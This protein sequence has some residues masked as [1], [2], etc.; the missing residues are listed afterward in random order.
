MYFNR[1]LYQ[2]TKGARGQLLAA[3]A[4]GLLTTGAGVGR[5]AF[6]GVAIAFLIEGRESGPIIMAF[7]AVILSIIVRAICQYGKEYLGHRAALRVQ[8]NMRRI[9]YARALT[10]GPGVLDQKRAGDLLVSLVEGVDQLESYFGEFIPQV[11]VAALT[12]LGLFVFMG[13]L[14]LTTAL[15]YLVC[16][17]FTLGAPWAFHKWN[18]TSSMKRRVSYGDLSAEFLDSVQGLA[19]LK[20]FGQSKAR[21]LVLAEKAREVYVNTMGIL[22]RNVGTT[23]VTWLGI[24][25]GAAIA[26]SFGAL[27][28]EQGSLELATLLVIVM[29]GV[30]VFRPLRELTMLYHKGMLGTSAATAIFDLLDSKV[31]V[32]STESDGN[33]LGALDSELEFRNV[34]FSYPTNDEKVLTNVSFKLSQGQT[35]GIV[36]PS[37]AGKSTLIWLIMRLFDPRSGDVLI[38]GKRLQDIPI[39]LL[40]ENLAVVTQDTYLFHGT[41]ADN[42][43]MANANATLHEIEI[44]ARSANA[45]DFIV[46][47]PNGYDT[48]IGERGIRLSGGQRQRIAIARALLK[49]A[50][51]LLLDE[52]LSNVDTENELI[53]QEAL[54]RLMVGR[55]TLV[56]AHRLSS[57]VGTDRI[58]VFDRGQLVQEG[59]HHKLIDETGVYYDLMSSQISVYSDG[60]ETYQSRAEEVPEVS[61]HPKIDGA[62]IGE[63]S[64]SDII[65]SGENRESIGKVAL[66][67][68]AL[69][70]PWKGMLTATFLLGVCRVSVLI[71]IGVTSALLVREVA[72]QQGVHVTPFVIILAVLAFLTPVFHWAESWLSHD[73][74][75]RLLAE[76]RVAL[77]K[78]LDPLAPAYLVKRRSGDIVALV[79]SDIET[80]EYFFGHTVAPAFVAL[81]VP[82]VVIVTMVIIQWEMAL[83][84][85]PFLLL[86]G[87]APVFSSRSLDKGASD[88]REKLGEINAHM[89]DGVQGMREIVAF[90]A[91]GKRLNE[92]V[93]NQRTFGQYRLHFLKMLTIQKVSIEIFIGI[94][95]ISVLALGA[96]FVDRGELAGTLLPLLSLIALASF[97]PVTELAQVAKSL[98]DTFASARRIFSVHDE[99]IPVKDGPGVNIESQVSGPGI[100][101]QNVVFSYGRGLDNALNDMSFEVNEGDTVAIVGRS[102]AG[103]TTSAHLLLRFW[104]PDS[105]S[106]KFSGHDL[107]GF[108]LDQLRERISMVSQDTYLFNTTIKENLRMAKPNAEEQEIIDAAINANMHDFVMGLPKQ[109][110][111]S[112]GERGMHLS[113]GQRQRLA[114]ARALLK[115][116][117]ILILDEATSHLDVVNENLVRDALNRLMVGRTTLIIAHRLSTVKDATKILVMDRGM[118]I[119]EG[120]HDELLAHGG[121]YR[122]LVSSQVSAGNLDRFA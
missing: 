71:G 63:T 77:Y 25:G 106:I 48:V 119:E 73:M 68:L 31:M 38:G 44:A 113:G 32:E 20:A 109:Y 21:G 6:S 91:E 27:R 101:F 83:A 120:T 17:L 61:V 115:G 26:L 43:R 37:G 18:A 78:K 15:I 62:N 95:G 92:V 1:R 33:D 72:G 67:L 86:V 114:I 75:F 7:F 74:A 35:I 108:N 50:P 85:I 4:F 80:I 9:L 89:I 54:N 59:P 40:R 3:V 110:N 52:A 112:V 76:M 13:F 57:I 104:D 30:E 84:L 55:T 51:I 90:G 29:L 122:H 98:T 41:V 102:G 58:L 87:A 117:P 8:L 39:T 53:I 34:T 10:L 5:L 28:V 99:P 81:A 105:G 66:R 23:G 111:T 116:A 19:T 82:T 36:G 64:S 11:A 56:I 45:H 16:A 46:A 22:A 12:P 94:G 42:L 47:L 2:F 14:D 24:T 49:D 97:I 93:E 96:I 65:G 70:G 121:L 118:V 88:A 103:K 60:N 79:T 100:V 107:R 69:V